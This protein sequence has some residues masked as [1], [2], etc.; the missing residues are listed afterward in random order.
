MK[1]EQEN[2]ERDDFYIPDP[3]D[4]FSTLGEIINY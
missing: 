3:I 2:E 1:T 4:L